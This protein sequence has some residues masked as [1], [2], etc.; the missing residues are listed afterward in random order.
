MQNAIARIFVC[1]GMLLTLSACGVTY[2]GRVIDADTKLPIDGA[3]VVASWSEERGTMAGGT[4]RL[5]DVKETLT[6]KN[7]DWSINGPKGTS[8]EF[9]SDVYSILTFITGAYYTEPPEFIVFKP[10]YCAWKEGFGIEVCNN[11]MK[12]YN[13]TVEHINIGE[14]VELPKLMSR[15]DR[16]RNLP[17]YIYDSGS[18]MKH[19]EILKNQ[20]EFIR[21][22]QEERKNLGL[23]GYKMPELE[24][25]K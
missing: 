18:A 24:N 22:L 14:I 17:D 6:D 23:S 13:G 2:H 8:S 3:V 4:S 7:G 10:G 1:I 11:K 19:N 5:H 25:E 16:L 20:K 12:T 9:L 15:G 21:L